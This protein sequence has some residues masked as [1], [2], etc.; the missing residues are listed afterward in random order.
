MFSRLLSSSFPS[1]PLLQNIENF[2]AEWDSFN[3]AT[4][5]DLCSPFSVCHTHTGCEAA[6][7][8]AKLALNWDLPVSELVLYELFYNMKREKCTLYE[9]EWLWL[10][11][12]GLL[13]CIRRDPASNMSSPARDL[14]RSNSTSEVS[15]PLWCLD[16]QLCPGN[17]LPSKFYGQTTSMLSVSDTFVV[18]AGFSGSSSTSGTRYPS[19]YLNLSS[20]VDNTVS[21]AALSPASDSKAASTCSADTFAELA[22]T[23]SSRVLYSF[24]QM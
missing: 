20:G 19:L 1:I 11:I 2:S 16:A 5:E 14:G 23:G 22:V 15:R 17:S 7:R 10:Q 9:R 21:P 4:E 12:S 18:S 3:S 6:H 24:F 13:L 8:K